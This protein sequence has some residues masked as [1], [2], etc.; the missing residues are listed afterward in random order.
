M[1][2]LCESY[3]CNIAT[4]SEAL[5]AGKSFDLIERR[6][7][8]LGGEVTFFFVDGFIKDGEMQRIMQSMISEAS[9][10]TASDMMR[11]LPY[12]EVC[13]TEDVGEL[14]VAVLSGQAAILSE[15]FGGVAILVDART[16]PARGT[17]EPSGDRVMQGAKDGFVETLI[18]NTALIS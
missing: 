7:S 18:F 17:E 4:V 10:L 9:P 15:S 2:R 8:A 6:I 12:V 14:T 1:K 13:A 5:A 11:R 16:Y 3:R